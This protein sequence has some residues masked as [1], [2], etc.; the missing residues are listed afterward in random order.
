MNEWGIPDWRDP[1]AYGD[2]KAW[3]D[4]RWRWEFRRR[5]DEFRAECDA[6]LAMEREL[7]A[8]YDAFQNTRTVENRDKFSRLVD[9]IDDMRFRHMRSWGYPGDLPA[10]DPRV[11]EYSD[12]V[13]KVMPH[14]K[15]PGVHSMVGS[16]SSE[17]GLSR[18]SPKKG[19][20]TITFN[21]DQSLS[22]NLELAE[23]IL[24]REQKKSIG[25]V[26]H[27]AHDPQ[28]AESKARLWLE[29]LRV[30]DGKEAKERKIFGAPRT[31][32]EIGLILYNGNEGAGDKARKAFATARKLAENFA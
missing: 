11:S 10:L 25:K 8:A 32:H 2:V 7:N 5:L 31:W 3:S 24:R 14:T 20:I 6:L 19:Q 9:E 28:T 29:Y 12:D 15:K 21:L 1:A 26:I 17:A 4:M 18:V 13:L 22:S 16:A 30:M 23:R 27:K